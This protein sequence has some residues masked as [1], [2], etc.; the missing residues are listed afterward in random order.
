[1]A[2]NNN[3]DIEYDYGEDDPVLPGP[4]P[5]SRL[6]SQSPESRTAGAFGGGAPPAPAASSSRPALHRRSP[7]RDRERDRERDR[8]RE[9]TNYQPPIDLNPEHRFFVLKC[10]Y[11][12]ILA[13][14]KRTGVWPAR[15]VVGDRLAACW[16]APAGS[17]RPRI[18]VFFTLEK[19]RC[20]A[21]VG[22][23][24]GPVRSTGRFEEVPVRW[25]GVRDVHF[26]DLPA[27]LL[28]REAWAD[29][30]MATVRDGIELPY[31]VGRSILKEFQGERV[32]EE[33]RTRRHEPVHSTERRH[34][35]H[36][37]RDPIRDRRVRPHY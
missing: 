22:D 1:M 31:A 21:A 10:E 12:A 8:D 29:P 27:G 28:P 36:H 13:Q 17:P 3:D 7:P 15:R 23:M 33:G 11:Y 32:Q 2:D 14:A 9:R 25:T 20:F 19:A 26:A 18:T 37:A 30:Q 35:D 4:P 5:A 16:D 6:R 24:D 34:D